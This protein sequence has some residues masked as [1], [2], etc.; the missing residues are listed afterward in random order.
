L[1]YKGLVA[2][3]IKVRLTLIALA[4]AYITGVVLW[5]KV[6]FHM[7]PH[8]LVSGVKTVQ[9]SSGSTSVPSCKTDVPMVSQSCDLSIDLPIGATAW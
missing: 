1:Y 5:T 8:I 9:L 2:M 7:E 6:T 4:L 3:L